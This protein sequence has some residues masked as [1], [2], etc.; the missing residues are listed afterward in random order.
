MGAALE[1]IGVPA[2]RVSWISESSHHLRTKQY[3]FDQLRMCALATQSASRETGE[4][5]SNT[6]MLSPLLCPIFQALDEEYLGADIQFGGVDQVDGAIS[7]SL[8]QRPS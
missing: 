2:T 4:E 8:L 1:A 3:F 7:L 6:T 5:L